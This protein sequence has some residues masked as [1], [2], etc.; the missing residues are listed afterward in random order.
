MLKRVEELEVINREMKEEL[1]LLNEK[2]NMVDSYSQHFMSQSLTL[3]SIVIAIAGL[4]IVGAA[5][6]M[7]KNMLNTKVDKEVENIVL[8]VLRKSKPIY[9]ANGK[10]LPN[11][12]NE[13][14][15]SNEIEGVDELLPDT[16]MMLE[17]SVNKLT[18]G[19]LGT[20][21]F[22]R[23]IINENGQ[24][25]IVIDN[26]VENGEEVSWVLAW[27]RKNYQY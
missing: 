8:K 5:Y 18:W 3:I 25:I 2:L 1:N 11:E 14:I 13:I 26:Y 17:V 12:K 19:Q 10:S 21:L 15:I 4:V 7:I 22:S 23:L 27:V 20:G 9:Y 24:R 16:L 6:F